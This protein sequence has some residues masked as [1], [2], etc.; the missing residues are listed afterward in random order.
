MLPKLIIG[1]NSLKKEDWSAYRKYLLMQTREDSEAFK[2]FSL[3]QKQRAKLTEFDTA[4]WHTKYVPQ[5]SE[6]ALLNTFSKLYLWLEEWIV[7]STLQKD[8]VRS[9]VELV[10]HWNRVGEFKLADSK[11]KQ[12]QAIL[13]DNDKYSPE[14]DYEQYRLYYYQF[15]SDNPVKNNDPD[16]IFKMIDSYLLSVEKEKSL[17]KSQVY[18]WNKLKPVEPKKYKSYIKALKGLE[19]NTINDELFNMMVNNDL[20][21]FYKCKDYLLKGN[22]LREDDLYVKLTMYLLSYCR[23]LWHKK[24]L[25][26]TK[27]MIEM[28]EFALEN[29]ILMNSGKLPF[30]RYLTIINTLGIFKSAKWTDEFIEKWAPKVDSEDKDGIINAGKAF[31]YFHRKMFNESYELLQKVNTKLINSR[32][33]LHR[34]SI[35]IYYETIDENLY[36][37]NDALDKYYSY[38]RRRKQFRSRN[39]TL[40]STNFRLTVI[41]LLDKERESEKYENLLPANST[42]W[43]LE[44]RKE[45]DQQN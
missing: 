21:S 19:T 29:N 6:K 28:Y 34:L 22:I 11:A 7:F 5:L 3:L 45:L 4:K 26:S 27:P 14:L 39:A 37:L 15:Y 25:Q 38:I 24:I 36:L 40:R 41:L 16:L 32:E 35:M 18:F 33:V 31:N 9:G 23:T 17:Y 8:K 43:L 13:D 42:K 2:C 44:K 20:D 10:K 1:L 30:Q 12:V